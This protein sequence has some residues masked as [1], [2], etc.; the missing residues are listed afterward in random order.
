MPQTLAAVAEAGIARER[1][2]GGDRIAAFLRRRF[3]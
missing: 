3:A 1:A 2:D